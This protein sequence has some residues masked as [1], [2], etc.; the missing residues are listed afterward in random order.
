VVNA[1]LEKGLSHSRGNPDFVHIQFE[2]IDEPIK[3]IKP[4]KIAT[5]EV[6]A[7]EMGQVLSWKLLEKVGIQRQIIEKA[8]KYY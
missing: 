5:N 4:L 3:H 8:Y 7:V 2:S 6:E 1:L